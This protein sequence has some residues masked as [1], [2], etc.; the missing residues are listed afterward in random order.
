MWTW[1]SNA[2]ACSATSLSWPSIW[3][4]APRFVLLSA[5][6]RT[7]TIATVVHGANHAAADQRVISCASCTTNCITPVVE[8][9][10]RR[11]GVAR[12]VMTTV[13]AYTSTQQLVDGPS[14]DF[15]R[16]R[17][18]AVN[19]LPA[20]TGAALATT[21]ALPELADRFDG[22]ATEDRRRRRPRQ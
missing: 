21:K 6:A 11:I 5:P 15:R 1:C 18:G 3:V 17:A 9:L 20:S 19:L 8:V 16:G 12:A 7:E 14:R 2:P 22:V 13:H 10:H 4:P